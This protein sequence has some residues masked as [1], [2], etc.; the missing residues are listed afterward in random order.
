MF[1]VLRLVNLSPSLAALTFLPV[2][3]AFLLGPMSAEAQGA[4]PTV[5]MLPGVK[6]VAVG[7][8]PFDVR[9]T[10]E[11]LQHEGQISYDVNRDTVPDLFVPS[12]G[13]AAFQFNIRY[14]PDVLSVIR[15][16]ESPDLE[17]KTGRTYQCLQGSSAPEVFAFACFS[18]GTTPDGL[19]GDATLAT[20]RFRAVGPGSSFLQLDGELAGPLSDDI[21]VDIKGAAVIVQSGPAPIA[22]AVGPTADPTDETPSPGTPPIEGRTPQPTPTDGRNVIANPTGAGP[23]GDDPQVIDTPG[24][25]DS[26][27]FG[28]T[29]LIALGAIG[30]AAALGGGGLL[31][32]RR[33][34]M[35]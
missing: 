15:A 20:V 10:V 19:Q 35:R 32:A 24:D 16:D 26:S 12:I 6:S 7:D 4:L 30:G 29:L 8:G 1:G 21:P 28:R 14:D 3:A 11:N 27:S 23:E 5:Q 34:W 22:T 17:G 18:G 9:I 2:A 25:E 33:W 31:A 13:M